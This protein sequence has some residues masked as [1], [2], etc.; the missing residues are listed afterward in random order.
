MPHDLIRKA[1]EEDFENQTSKLF[2]KKQHTGRNAP[3]A[4][5]ESCLISESDEEK[6][7]NGGV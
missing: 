2:V 7:G 3:L 5:A 4:P 6:I 1:F